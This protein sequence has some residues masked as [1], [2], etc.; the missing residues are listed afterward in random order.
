MFSHHPLTFFLCPPP[1]PL[2]SFL[3]SK[4]YSSADT[5]ILSLAAGIHIGEKTLNIWLSDS[6][7]SYNEGCHVNWSKWLRTSGLGVSVYVLR[8]TQPSCARALYSDGFL[9]FLWALLATWYLLTTM[10][11]TTD[12][13]GNHCRNLYGNVSQ[14]FIKALTWGQLCHEC[15]L[16]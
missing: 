14:V 2:S 10:E 4:C 1:L 6:G 13:K 11:I 5:Q 16:G 8:R 9:H 15:N 3:A 12:S 7:T